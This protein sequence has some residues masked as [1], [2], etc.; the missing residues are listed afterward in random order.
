MADELVICPLC[1]FEFESADTLCSHGCPLQINCTH[2]RCPSCEYEFPDQ[3]AVVSWIKRL[4]SRAKQA[5]APLCGSFRTVKDLAKGETAEIVALSSEGARL[6][7]L[8]VFGLVPGSE[9][10]LLQ[11]DPAFVIRIGETE[12][13]LEAA[14]ADSIVI[15]LPAP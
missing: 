4:F 7:N 3:P 9:V 12:L 14:I 15:G 10:T 13:A 6:N 11:R 1:G 8:A 2:I 5:Q